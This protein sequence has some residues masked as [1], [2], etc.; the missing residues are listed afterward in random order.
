MPIYEREEEYIKL[1]SVSNCTVKNLSKKLFIS[2][3]TVRRD[4]NAMK[5]KGL[6]ESKR[7]VISLKINSPDSRIPVSVRDVE[8][9][10]EKDAIAKIAASHIKDGQTIILD[11][12]TTAL[13]IAPYL[14]PFKDI[15]VI[16]N[17]IKTAYTLLSMNVKTI[18]IGGMVTPKSYSCLSVDAEKELN[19][20]NADICF[21]SA[22]GIN[23]KGIIT[24][25][26]IEGNA[27]KK[28]M[29]KNSNESYLLIDSSK[30]G[31]TL[32]NTLCNKN[33]LT[34]VICDKDLSNYFEE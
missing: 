31:K 24:D 29:I 10:T 21:F 3:P 34:G 9:V 5:Q 22:R 1:L 14:L 25:N 20:Y 2:E 13:A 32:F 33:E 27:I 30:V 28:V 18:V 11:S 16:T 26:S 23:E 7:G 4:I 17:G 6:I 15:L 8:R 12:S 19:R